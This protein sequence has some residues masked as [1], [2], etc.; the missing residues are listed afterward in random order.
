LRKYKAHPG[1]VQ[2]T[3]QM[4]AGATRDRAA[5][6]RFLFLSTVGNHGLLPLLFTPAEYP[7]K[8]RAFVGIA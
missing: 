8:V 7:I 4:A 3:V 6:S 2:V 1:S 5:A